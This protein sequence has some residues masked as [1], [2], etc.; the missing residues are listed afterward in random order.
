VIIIRISE[1][2]YGILKNIPK[3][4]HYTEVAEKAGF[5]VAYVSVKIKDLMNKA[6]ITFIPDY[7]K[8]GLIPSFMLFED[9][10]YSVEYFE[11]P[12]VMS[13]G[14]IIGE[15]E[16]FFVKAVIPEEHLKT[17]ID[18]FREKPVFHEIG[19]VEFHWNP[20]SPLV[21]YSREGFDAKLEDFTKVFEKELEQV[22]IFTV[23][24]RVSLDELDL[25][26]IKEK[27]RDPF[28]SLTSMGKS[29]EKSQQLVSYHFH[30]HVF[31]LW[32]YNAVTLYQDYKSNPLGL[33]FFEF[34]DARTAKG[35]ARALT[36]LP[37]TYITFLSTSRP[38]VI[39]IANIPS[40]KILEFCKLVQ[41]IRRKNMLS[42]FTF[43]GYLD[44][45]AFK[46]YTIS[47]K[48][49]LKNG[50]WVLTGKGLREVAEELPFKLPQ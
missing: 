27:M 28:K 41:S 10:G 15:K 17:Y 24:K 3:A 34:P 25:Y 43:K 1:S 11:K 37:Y 20:A 18:I 46:E 26:I 38:L 29:V 8:M 30:K 21:V 39:Y 7:W 12:Y 31:P 13:I 44:P 40:H 35:F 45:E 6:R 4:L 14:K 19:L 2:E 32:K 48:D 9:K 23:S 49:V 16:Y 36:Y 5:T 22:E 42:T 47:Y 50:E 33:Y